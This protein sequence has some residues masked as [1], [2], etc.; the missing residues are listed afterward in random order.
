MLKKGMYVRVPANVNEEEPR[1]FYLGII[2]E[3]DEFSKTLNIEFYDVT[4]ISIYYEKPNN[5]KCKFR[6]ALHCK[7][8]VDTE[9]I[10]K[11]E[12]MIVKAFNHN[13][14]DDFYYYYLQKDD[15]SLLYAC[16]KDIQ[17]TFNEGQVNP[18]YQL[19]KY[20]FQNPMWFIGR[21]IV[22]KTIT[23]INNSLYGFKD[24]V[25]CK[26][27]LKP[28]QLKTVM[29]C[30]QNDSC[31]VMIADEVGLGKTIEALSVLKVYMNEK[32]NKN[33]LISVPDALVEQW[34]NELA[35][36]FKLFVGE[37]LNNNNIDLIKIS[38][39]SNL[40]KFNY[41]FVII[42]EVHRYIDGDLYNTILKISMNAKNIIMLSATPLQNR[43]EELL[44]LLKLIN[45][46]KYLE[47]PVERFNFLLEEQNKITR[48]IYNCV[49]ELNV[50]NE[51]LND[52]GADEE[53]L[54][55]FDGIIMELESLSKIIKD[56]YYIDMLN[57]IS[58]DVDDKGL[59]SI[60]I[61][62]AYICENYQLEKAII[63]NRRKMIYKNSEENE[64]IRILDELYYELENDFN[65][66]E[67]DAYYT[68]SNWIENSHI[69]INDYKKYIID[70]ISRFFSS[71]AAYFQKIQELNDIFN[72]GDEVILSAQ[73]YYENDIFKSRN[74]NDYLDDPEI[75]SCRL[76]NLID[77]I[78]QN[79]SDYKIILFTNYDETFNYYKKIISDIF[80][81]DVCCYFNKNMTVDELELAAYR[82]QNEKKY[83]ILLSDQSG[84][85]GRNFQH[86]DCIIHIDIPWSANDLEQRIGRL[87]R[88][89]REKNKN[90][91]S[92]VSY[93]KSTIEEELFNIWHNGLNIFEKSQ[94]GL[95][96]IMNEIDK[97]IIYSL[98]ESFKYGLRQA[99]TE[100]DNIIIIQ[101]E[102]LKK[103]Q[104]V[105][106]AG[107]QYQTINRMLDRTVE[108]YCAEETELF[109]NA[110]MSWAS[111]SGFRGDSEG[112]NVIS[113]SKKSISVKSLSNTMFI[114]PNMKAIIDN[115]LNQ[116]R[117]RIR[118]LNDDRLKKL[119]PDYIRGTFDRKIA[120]S[121]DYLN[122][123]APGDDI[124]D[125]ITKNAINSYK[126]TCSAFAFKGSIKWT[127]LVFTWKLEIDNKLIYE[128]GLNYHYIDQYRGFVPSEQFISIYSIN[129]TEIDDSKIIH[130]YQKFIKNHK[131]SQKNVIHLGQRGNGAISKFKL[132]YP[133]EKWDEIIKVGV[134]YAKKEAKIKA[135]QKSKPLLNSLKNELNSLLG[136]SKALSNFYLVDDTSSNVEDMNN[137]IYEIILKSQ[138]VL[139]SVC[140]VVIDDGK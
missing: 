89:G 61:A 72:F 25:G 117:N 105:D 80:G 64:N 62:I 22:S 93:S 106:I 39:I 99:R 58:F 30:L 138:L 77:Y 60:Q 16:E 34:K 112:S 84:G 118:A 63:R 98:S 128:S 86:A 74:L 130:E 14:D 70:L 38:D 100:M 78:D 66:E 79:C 71:G 88:I 6:Q 110:M 83:R 59:S 137:K 131:E 44:K 33:I 10:Y 90:V 107:Y 3:V 114:P 111:L 75:Y 20:E 87:D 76:V 17:A 68:L 1:D 57:S 35:F 113:F 5:I 67:Y 102:T 139:D 13:S 81:D 50:F 95:E 120:L 32:K 103:E 18:L 101:L 55:I 8:K 45:P 127:G 24:L 116:L 82:F 53:L 29:R 94:S 129:E 11:K 49:D 91:I 48:K 19:K 109:S 108:K 42:D 46:R 21:S 52:D 73:K 40:L 65:N 27:I 2:K 136:A 4:G 115:K 9:V 54:E 28:Y 23:N 56:D 12:K 31:R 37:N 26:I 123:Y 135:L 97:K 140:Y 122:F 7:L 133:K 126:G 121:N 104:L 92:V 47:M 134:E 43:N 96:I 124:F 51:L 69:S 125:C 132:L 119:D 15:S 85:E 36:K 41:D